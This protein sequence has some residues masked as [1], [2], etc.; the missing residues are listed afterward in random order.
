MAWLKMSEND[1]TQLITPEDIYARPTTPRGLNQQAKRHTLRP[2]NT[3][4]G[5][6]RRLRL[7]NDWAS[8]RPEI[9]ALRD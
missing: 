6:I 3:S 9:L 1:A 2:V 4:G 5:R 8:R 7:S